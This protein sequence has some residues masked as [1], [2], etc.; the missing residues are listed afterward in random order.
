M[1]RSVRKVLYALLRQQTVR[2]DNESLATLFCEVEVV[3]NSR[4]ITKISSDANDVDAITPNHLLLLIP[5]HDAPCG[6]LSKDDN[7]AR[8]RWRQIQFLADMFWTR[9]S[10]EYLLSLQEHQKWIQPKSNVS[11]GDVVLVINNSPRSSWAPG[12]VVSVINDK[13]GFVRV[14]Q[15][16]TKTNVLCRPIHKLCLI[17]EAESSP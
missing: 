1:I 9:W 2:L 3:L 17:L 12:R 10:K 11:V 15:V 14:V 7:Y 16:K 5:G 6:V 4:P 8:R 13:K